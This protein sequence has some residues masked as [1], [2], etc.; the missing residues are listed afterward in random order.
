MGLYEVY[1]GGR[2][3]FG[4]ED[5]LVLGDD[6]DD[7][8]GELWVDLHASSEPVA[9]SGED[10]HHGDDIGFFVEFFDGGSGFD[11]FVGGPVVGVETFVDFL[12]HFGYEFL[13]RKGFGGAERVP[14]ARGDPTVDGLSGDTD[15]LSDSLL[16]VALEVVKASELAFFVE[17]VLSRFFSGN[18]LL[19]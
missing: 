7:F 17:L 15:A 6:L 12:E 9:E 2:H 18:F 19:L 4:D 5:V 3:L 8:G 1:F 14:F 16:A 10:F 13:T 11:D